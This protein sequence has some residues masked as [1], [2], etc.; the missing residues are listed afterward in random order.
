MHFIVI[1]ERKAAFSNFHEHVSETPSLLNPQHY[2]VKQL[3]A[4][5]AIL[6]HR[7]HSASSG[8]MMTKVKRGIT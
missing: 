5:F 6:F 3:I 7:E 2:Y 8:S 4:K 1:D